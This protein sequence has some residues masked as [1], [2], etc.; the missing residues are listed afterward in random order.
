[1]H[2]I[3]EDDDMIEDESPESDPDFAIAA[4]YVDIALCLSDLKNSVD[5]ETRRTARELAEL[6]AKLRTYIDAKSKNQ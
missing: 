2:D 6:L 3:I 5:G 4:I 1:M